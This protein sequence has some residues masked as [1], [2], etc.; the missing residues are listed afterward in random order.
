[1]PNTGHT[2]SEGWAI[3]LAVKCMRIQAFPPTLM[4]FKN[5]RPKGTHAPHLECSDCQYQTLVACVPLSTK[6]FSLTF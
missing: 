4:T 6:Y 3:L 2:W 5:Y 1:M